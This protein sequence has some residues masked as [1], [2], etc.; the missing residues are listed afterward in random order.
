M[1]QATPQIEV[2]AKDKN[3]KIGFTF[4]FL[5]LPLPFTFTRYLYFGLA[6]E[7][8]EVLD[9]RKTLNVEK[10]LG[11]CRTFKKKSNEI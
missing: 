1:W 7:G 11:F 3:I 6:T 2:G 5:P 8:P 4:T 10:N 9:V